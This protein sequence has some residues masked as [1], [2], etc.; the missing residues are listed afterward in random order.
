MVP[1][2]RNAWD[3]LAL[4]ARHDPVMSFQCLFAAWVTVSCV[5]AIHVLAHGVMRKRFGRQIDDIG[6]LLLYFQPAF[7]GDVSDAWIPENPRRL[8]VTFAGAYSE[9]LV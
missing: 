1:D 3:E 4:D 6:F 2:V 5:I 8:W 7:Y 9:M